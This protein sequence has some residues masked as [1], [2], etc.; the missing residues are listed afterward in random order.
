M[1]TLHE[2]AERLGVHYMTAYRYVRTGRLPAH[3]RGVQWLVDPADLERL[4]TN[5]AHRPRGGARR[6]SPGLLARRLLAG[7]E[8]GSWAL[9]ESTLASGAEPDGV[10]IDLLGAALADIGDGWAAGTLDVADEHRATV[11]AQRLI[12]R[13][14]P[15][16]AHRGRKR[17]T[18][19]MGAPAGEEHA[20]PSAILSDVLRGARFEVHDL[21]ADTPPG[22]FAIA[23]ERTDRLTGV[24]IGVTTPG[25]DGAVRDALTALRTAG[26]T[27]PLVVGGAAIES[28]AHAARLGADHWSG[29]DARAAL[30]TVEGLVGR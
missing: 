26:V 24:M 1:I 11:I 25:N 14:G 13:L 27:A 23:A 6:A 2:A 9:L 15:R 30:A 29:P 7:D 21:G 4:A 16:F 18:I 28:A 19:V 3:R 12:G 10:V 8:A 17:G 5:G 22:A 20:L